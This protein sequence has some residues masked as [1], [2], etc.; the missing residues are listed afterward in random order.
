MAIGIYRHYQNEQG[1]HIA[2]THFNAGC[3]GKRSGRLWSMLITRVGEM[4][5]AF[6]VSAT[7][8][9]LDWLCCTYL[10][11]IYY[12]NLYPTVQLATASTQ[13]G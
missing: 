11:F 8:F 4:L 10:L 2:P 5:F 3:V 9:V 1:S 7:G 6:F 12:F 13:G